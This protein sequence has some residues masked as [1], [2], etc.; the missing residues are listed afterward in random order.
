MDKSLEELKEDRNRELE[1]IADYSQEEIIDNLEKGIAFTDVFVS[2]YQFT[3]AFQSD[4]INIMFAGLC[5]LRA[6]LE[7]AICWIEGLDEKDIEA[8][9]TQDDGQL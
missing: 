4:S 5:K 7:N 6:T 2:A 8:T 1:E 3:G 9:D